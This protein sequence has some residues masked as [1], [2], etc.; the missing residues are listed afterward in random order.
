MPLSFARLFLG[1]AGLLFMAAGRVWADAPESFTLDLPFTAGTVTPAWLG[2]PVTPEATFATLGLPVQPANATSF[3][4]VT[5]YFQ[6]KPDGFLRIMWQG[7]GQGAASAQTLSDNFY[8]GIGMGNQRSLLISPET[9]AGGGTLVFQCGDTTLGI[10]RIRMQWLVSQDGLVAPS[11][12]DTM[13]TPAPGTTQPALV[14][15]GQPIPADPAAW[16][17]HLVNVPITDTPQRIEQGVEFSVQLDAAPLSGRLAL[18][19]NGLP[20]G[21]HLVVWINQQRAGTITPSVPNLLDDGY[22]S[23][24]APYAGW[25][26][27]SMYVP[28]SVFRAGADTVQFSVEDDGPAVASTPSDAA[29]LAVKDVVL[30]LNYPATPVPV[31]AVPALPAPPPPVAPPPATPSLEDGNSPL[32]TPGATALPSSSSTPTGPVPSTP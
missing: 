24:T 19:E 21:K 13:V 22:L 30:Q 26:E 20:W 5:V 10:A 14:F 9:M 3:L 28:A 18:K 27:G 25:R 8:E 31:P 11:I 23:P 12:A 32:D 29:P 6:E 17:G 16:R 2:Q 4:L 7:P 1:I 15:S